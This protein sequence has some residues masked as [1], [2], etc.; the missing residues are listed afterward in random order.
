MILPPTSTALAKK[1]ALEALL[2]DLAKEY[3]YLQTVIASLDESCDPRF[4]EKRM[5]LSIRAE[6]VER[7]MVVLKAG[8]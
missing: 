8:M 5:L 1:K 7:L 2:T 6:E 3:G 4:L